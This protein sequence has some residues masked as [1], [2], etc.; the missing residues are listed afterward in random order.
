MEAVYATQSQDGKIKAM[1]GLYSLD[2]DG[3]VPALN[4]GSVDNQTG[5]EAKGFNTKWNYQLEPSRLL[6]ADWEGSGLVLAAFV[7]R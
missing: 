4:P 1:F 7:R 5:L 3:F 2:Y 6:E